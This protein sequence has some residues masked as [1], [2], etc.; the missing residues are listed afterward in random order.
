[1]LVHV[2][3]QVALALVRAVEGKVIKNTFHKL[4]YREEIPIQNPPRGLYSYHLDT[5]E[6]YSHIHLR[7]D[8]GGDGLLIINANRVLHLK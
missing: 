6:G 5:H 4:F 2:P 8:E 3:V 1:V 7:V